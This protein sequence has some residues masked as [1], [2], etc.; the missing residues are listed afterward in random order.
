MANSRDRAYR[1]QTVRLY[2]YFYEN[3]VLTNPFSPGTVYIHS[4]NDVPL[5][6]LSG[7]AP[8]NPSAGS[9]Y[10]EWNIPAD[11]NPQYYYDVW[12]GIQLLPASLPINREFSVAVLYAPTEDIPIPDAVAVLS[13]LCR[14]YD[15]FVTS[16][17]RALSNMPAR[18]SIVTLPSESYF[19]TFFVNFEEAVENY[20]DN[21]G[22][23]DWY[24]PRGSEV[25]IEVRSTGYSEIKLVPDAE[26]VQIRDM[27][28]ASGT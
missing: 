25:H 7:I 4:G 6:G 9:Y 17:G 22:R 13:G 20:T 2:S 19:D 10:I 11:Q 15:F 21:N 1:G 24:F 5:A 14:I 16:D 12:S 18:A 23:V 3:G 28:D 8:Y 26:S 27:E